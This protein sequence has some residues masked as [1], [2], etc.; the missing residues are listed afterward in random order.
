MRIASIAFAVAAAFVC[1]ASA[2]ERAPYDE[3][4]AKR[5]GADERGMRSYVLAILKTGPKEIKSKEE[6]QK[7]FTGH[8]GNIKRLAGEGKLAVAGPLG[9]NAHKYEGVF[10]LTVAT[11]ADADALLATDPA[12]AGGYLTY[13]AYVWYGSASLMETPAIHERIDKT[14]R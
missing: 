7:I 12:I 6:Q 2:A 8:I 9:E 1:E 11:I 14:G 3:A 10:I 5:L 13:E 4:L